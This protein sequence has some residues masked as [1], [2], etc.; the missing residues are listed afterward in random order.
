MQKYLNTQIANPDDA[1]SHL[2]CCFNGWYTFILYSHIRMLQQLIIFLICFD[3]IHILIQ[4]A[5]PIPHQHPSDLEFAALN[6]LW[7]FETIF[8]IMLQSCF[9]RLKRWKQHH[10][11]W[12]SYYYL[13][14]IMHLVILATLVILLLWPTMLSQSWVDRFSSYFQGTAYDWIQ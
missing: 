9:L 2:I 12:R 7:Y 6:I 1:K 5:L 10:S 3:I 11:F 8:C 13:F 4:L 14:K